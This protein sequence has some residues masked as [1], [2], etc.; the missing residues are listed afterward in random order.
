MVFVGDFADGG[1]RDI[2]AAVVGGSDGEFG[3]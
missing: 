3:F 2:I 1:T